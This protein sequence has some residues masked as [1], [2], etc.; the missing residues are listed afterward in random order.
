[1]SERKTRNWLTS[2]VEYASYGEAPKKTLFW[3]GVSTIAGALRRKVWIEQK[4]YH[5]TPCFYIILT[6]PPGIISKS[7]TA[8]LGM[9]LLRDIPDVQFGPDVVTWQALLQRFGEAQVSFSEASTGLYHSMSALTIC[10]DEL[11][12]LL[13]PSNREFVDTLTNL[14]D[15]KRGV[16][17]K[18]TKGSGTDVIVN[19]WLNIL[20][21][22]TPGWLK[23]NFTEALIGGGF[24]SRCLF[25]YADKKRQ[26]VAYPARHMPEH[27]DQDKE[28]LIHDLELI[29]QMVGEYELTDE[30]MDWGE[31]WYQ[32]LD[33][34]DRKLNIEQFGGYYSRKQ[35]H[36]HKLAMVLAAAK[37]SELIIDLQTLMVAKDF[38]EGLE[39]EMGQVFKTIGQNQTGRG[40]SELLRV[41]GVKH[42]LTKP[43]LF[44]ELVH[45]MPNMTA[46]DFEAAIHSAQLAG[47]IKLESNSNMTYIVALD[48]PKGD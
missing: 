45:L 38:V 39:A 42:R 7:T 46:K 29:S 5:W 33:Q 24:S 2:F 20:G 36:V 26:L 16:I 40:L 23:A 28:D 47:H 37:S 4:I 6:A 19:P 31:K 8:N 18:L 22:T 25:V 15:S 10:S 9:N 30:A 17:T 34:A 35:A 44:R 41:V 3:T 21:C 13:D 1:M 43:N 11:G 14:W 32:E 27:M 12:N 48:E